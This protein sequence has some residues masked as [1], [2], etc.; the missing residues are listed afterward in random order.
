[1][2]PSSPYPWSALN[3]SEPSIW[4]RPALVGQDHLRRPLA[5]CAGQSFLVS[6][7][8]AEEAAEAA[9]L[10]ACSW[11]GH[12]HQSQPA[13]VVRYRQ[14][15]IDTL[16]DDVVGGA[17]LMPLAGVR[18]AIVVEL[19][20]MPRADHLNTLLKLTE[21]PPAYLGLFIAAAARTVLP[22]TLRS[23]LFPLRLQPLPED[24]L[25]EWLEQSRAIA[26]ADARRA[27]R[28]AEG[29][30]QQALALS[31]SVSQM[32]WPSLREDLR[33]GGVSGLAAA[34]PLVDGMGELVE[35]LD[36]EF[37]EAELDDRGFYR[38]A[39]W[40]LAL[41]RRHLTRNAN[42]RVVMDNLLSRLGSD[43]AK[44]DGGQDLPVRWPEW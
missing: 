42:R 11:S 7:A 28:Q 6:A 1:M 37:A 12:E 27:A 4:D 25:C 5:R 30:A 31:A 44:V 24:R 9:W 22:R 38:R 8:R 39:R 13:D 10:L 2:Q 26:P 3:D 40:H 32:R 15:D 21:E 18:K 43:L 36:R 14:P 20:E 29:W 19:M 17:R 23:R 33:R 41:A 35:D 34:G 16:R